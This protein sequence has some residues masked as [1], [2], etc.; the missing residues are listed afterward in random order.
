M[1]NIKVGHKEYQVAQIISDTCSILER[2]NKKFFLRKLLELRNGGNM[3]IY[4]AKRLSTSG[5][6]FPKIVK[7]D[8]KRGLMLTQYLE[9]ENLA[10]YLGKSDMT[11]DLFESLFLN[12]YMARRSALTL[13]YLPENFI[14][15]KGKVFYT[16]PFYKKYDH[17]EDLTE[18]YIRLYFNTNELGNYLK[19][20]GISYDISRIKDSYATNKQIVL[21][22]CKHY[23]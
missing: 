10:S 3:Q 1:E 4:C 9:G 22:T 11:D 16:Y 7:I 12:Q 23:K 8:K 14:I 13:D 15:V 19:K 17:K 5:I 18:K 20:L 6:N 2:K 21:T